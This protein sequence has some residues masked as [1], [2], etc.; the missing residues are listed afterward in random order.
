MTA[1]HVVFA[2]IGLGGYLSFIVLGIL[3][4][5]VDMPDGRRRFTLR[6][7]AWISLLAGTFSSFELIKHP[8]WWQWAGYLFAFAFLASRIEHWWKATEKLRQAERGPRWVKR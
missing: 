4:W 6:L 3:G 5:L 7:W 2:S 8:K 1:G